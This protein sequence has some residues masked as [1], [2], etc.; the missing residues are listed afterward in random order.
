MDTNLLT[1]DN[2]MFATTTLAAPSVIKPVTVTNEPQFSQAPD[3]TYQ[4]S[5]TYEPITTDKIS[6][7]G[8]REHISKPKQDF[9]QALRKVEDESSQQDQKNAKSDKEY[10]VS[11]LTSKAKPTESPSTSEIPITHGILVKENA[12]KMEPK[13]GSQLAQLIA[14]PKE[15]KFNSIIEQTAKSADI[16]QPVTTEKD[17]SGPKSILPD[18]FS[19]QHKLH[20]SLSNISKGISI[21]DTQSEMTKMMIRYQF[22]MAM[23]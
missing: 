13:T 5:N 15:N 9:K 6:S 18:S 8:Q 17:Q 4:Y 7:I 11:E 16:K 3:N 21:T 12:T 1:I 19:D 2:M 22:Q 14:N 10:S 20:T 23:S